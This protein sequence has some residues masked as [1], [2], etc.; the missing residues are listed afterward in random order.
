MLA[1]LLLV[2]GVNTLIPFDAVQYDTLGEVDIAVQNAFIPARTGYYNI[3]CHAILQGCTA[4]TLISL[5]F[6]INAGA[7]D[8]INMFALNTA[9][10]DIHYTN[11]WY[12]QAGD[13]IQAYIVH[14]SVGNRFLMGS[15]ADTILTGFRYS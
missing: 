2:T 13:V 9:R 14:N 12:L 10:E 5:Q 6:W 3:Q 11:L 15:W 7:I 1:N 4:G 8:Q